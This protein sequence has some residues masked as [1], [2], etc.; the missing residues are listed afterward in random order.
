MRRDDVQAVLNGPV[1]R[2]LLRPGAVARLAYNGLDGSPRAIPT[3]VHF[4][5]EHLVMCTATNAAKVPALRA[6]PKVALTVDTTGSPPR[7]LLLRGSV[8]L[9]VVDGVPEE[10][11]VA[12]TPEFEASVRATYDQ[13]VRI[14]V[15]VEWAKAIDF[16]TNLPSA[17]EEILRRKQVEGFS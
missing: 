12:A 14:R 6:N 16:E 1:A 15:H 3:G 8:D 13:M 11:L 9:E 4:N 7:A 17:V 5:G 2:E 10:F